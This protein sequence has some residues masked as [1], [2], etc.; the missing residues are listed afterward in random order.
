MFFG[1]FAFGAMSKKKK[2]L[3]YGHHAYAWC[4]LLPFHC[5]LIQSVHCVGDFRAAQQK[6]RAAQR[7]MEIARESKNEKQS[8]EK[9]IVH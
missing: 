9:W 4:I 6:K 7:M 3:S 5:R 8:G 1:Y 2:R